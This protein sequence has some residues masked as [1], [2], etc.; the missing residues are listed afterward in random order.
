MKKSLPAFAALALVG[1][2]HTQ[3]RTTYLEEYAGYDCYELRAERL[4]VEAELDP[5]W[6]QGYSSRNALDGVQLLTVTRVESP[7]S[8]YD[9]YPEFMTVD[10]A[11]VSRQKER[12]R[13]HA[14]WQALQQTPAP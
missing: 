6:R 1:C 4:I 10:P 14:K 13:N 3:Y 8:I 2:A 12:M 11:K 7:I 5:R 9:I